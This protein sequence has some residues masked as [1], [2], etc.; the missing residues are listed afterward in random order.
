MKTEWWCLGRGNDTVDE[1]K[2]KENSVDW[3]KRKQNSLF[4]FVESFINLSLKIRQNRMSIMFSFFL[5]QLPE[6]QDWFGSNWIWFFR[7]KLNLELTFFFFSI[8][9][10][11]HSLCLYVCYMRKKGKKI[12]RLSE[13]YSW[14]YSYFSNFDDDDGG[15][16]GLKPTFALILFIAF[17]IFFP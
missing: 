16:G 10:H 11:S 12:S 8:L 6:K 9:F 17:I 13:P 14:L 1:W 4:L 2:M 15:G 5:Y 3:Q 7:R